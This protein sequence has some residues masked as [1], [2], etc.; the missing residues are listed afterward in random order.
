MLDGLPVFIRKDFKPLVKRFDPFG[1]VAQTFQ[2]IECQKVDGPFPA[3][4]AKGVFPRIHL[5]KDKKHLVVE[6]HPVHILGSIIRI[7]QI[8]VFFGKKILRAQPGF[9]NHLESVH[10]TDLSTDSAAFASID[11]RVDI[12]GKLFPGNSLGRFLEDFEINGRTFGDRFVGNCRVN[13]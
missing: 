13:G 10:R 12:H 4:G 11:N 8:M 5:G 7:V 2:G 3:A 1:T 9:I 6:G